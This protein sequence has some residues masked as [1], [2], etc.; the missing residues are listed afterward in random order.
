MSEHNQVISKWYQKEQDDQIWCPV[1]RQCNLAIFNLVK[2]A[3]VCADMKVCVQPHYKTYITKRSEVDLHRRTLP[4]NKYL[5]KVASSM[6][7]VN[8]K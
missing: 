5:L 6:A 7:Y 2:R 8:Q 1:V 3:R 4:V